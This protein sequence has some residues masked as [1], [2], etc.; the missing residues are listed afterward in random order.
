[1]ELT[2]ILYAVFS[3]TENT[4]AFVHAFDKLER[5]EAFVNQQSHLYSLPMKYFVVEYTPNK[6]VA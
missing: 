5:A 6:K 4:Q 2:P 1:M 3:E